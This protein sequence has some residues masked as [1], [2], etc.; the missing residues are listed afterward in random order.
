MRILSLVA[1]VVWFLPSAAAA[2]LDFS[3]DFGSKVTIAGTGAGTGTFVINGTSTLTNSDPFYAPLVNSKAS[4]SG[5][6][7]ISGIVVASLQDLVASVSGTQTYMLTTASGSSLTGNLTWLKIDSRNVTANG[8]LNLLNID[9]AVNLAFT[10]IT[11]NGVDAAQDAALSAL[12]SLGGGILRLNTNFQ[13]SNFKNLNQMLV[14]GVTTEITGF[15]MNFTPA[16]EPGSLALLAAAGA[17]M[18]R[19]RFHSA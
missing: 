15:T 19:R 2:I 11:L 17:V 1:L 5:T 8:G 3:S 16:P 4:I 6:D 10:T 14:N 18:L 12:N 7:L 9:S 13:A